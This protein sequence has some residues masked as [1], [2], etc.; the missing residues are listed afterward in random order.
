MNKLDTDE[1]K[2]CHTFNEY[3]EYLSKSGME[4]GVT[5]IEDEDKLFI[6]NT[7]LAMTLTVLHGKEE[8]VID[9]FA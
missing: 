7:A 6:L 9:Y 2:V 5:G 1:C 8:E 4:K 3:F